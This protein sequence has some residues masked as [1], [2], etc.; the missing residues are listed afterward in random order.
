MTTHPAGPPWHDLTRN[1]ELADHGQPD[2][3][4][5]RPGSPDARLLNLHLTAIGCS[6]TDADR[7]APTNGPPDSLDQTLHHINH[8]HPENAHM[9]LDDP[10]AAY[11]AG[12]LAAQGWT[13]HRIALVFNATDHDLDQL[14]GPTHTPPPGQPPF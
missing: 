5:V 7:I 6:Q 13:R 11:L 8:G 2:Q 4:R 14:T 10:Y 12:H 3:I 9:S 1:V